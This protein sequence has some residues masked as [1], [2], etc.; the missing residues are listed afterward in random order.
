MKLSEKLKKIIEDNKNTIK[1]VPFGLSLGLPP[2]DKDQ[3]KKEGCTNEEIKELSN[4]VNKI[5]E[6][7]FGPRNDSPP[8]IGDVQSSASNAPPSD[9]PHQSETYFN[10]FSVGDDVVSSTDGLDINDKPLTNASDSNKVSSDTTES[11]SK[12]PPHQEKLFQKIAFIAVPSLL[13]AALFGLI[14]I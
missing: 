10:N 1:Q 5:V 13:A 9:T 11:S 8:S 7:E 14:L 2:K 6:G 4:E 3:L 12:K